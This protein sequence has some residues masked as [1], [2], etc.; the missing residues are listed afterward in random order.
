MFFVCENLKHCRDEANVN[1]W[2]LHADCQHFPISW[3]NHLMRAHVVEGLQIF[4]VIIYKKNTLRS[5]S[6]GEDGLSNLEGGGGT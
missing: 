6:V 3:F 2:W 1:K 5:S 4:I